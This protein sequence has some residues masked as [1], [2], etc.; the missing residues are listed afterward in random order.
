M[1]DAMGQAILRRD[2]VMF[3]PSIAGR[4]ELGLRRGSSVQCLDGGEVTKDAGDVVVV[5]RCYLR[6]GMA[7]ASAS[8]PGS[9]QVGVVTGATSTLDLVRLDGEHA[10]PVA[11]SPETLR[12]VS[13]FD[14]GDYVVS[15]PWL[16]WVFEVSL[17]VDVAID[18]DVCRGH[19]GG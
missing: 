1:E 10:R 13:E 6:V 11:V 3:K 16:G 12:R 4:H 7:V 15:G 18:G 8:D 5:D 9:G 17:D 19:A 14:L 2:T